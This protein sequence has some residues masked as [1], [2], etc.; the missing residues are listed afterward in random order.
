MIG[1]VRRRTHLVHL[2]RYSWLNMDHSTSHSSCSNSDCENSSEYD[3]SASNSSEELTD[4]QGA[5]P[6][7]FEKY[8][9]DASDDNIDNS[10]LSD[11]SDEIPARLQNTDWYVHGIKS[12]KL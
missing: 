3:G 8:E 11:E 6:Y 9:T 10:D 12:W 7:M 1:D 2:L 5:K 4:C